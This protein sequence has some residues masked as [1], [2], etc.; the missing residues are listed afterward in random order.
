[1]RNNLDG[2][3]TKSYI[4]NTQYMFECVPELVGT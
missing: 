2:D 4:M 3:V 1:M